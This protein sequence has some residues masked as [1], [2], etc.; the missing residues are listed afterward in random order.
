MEVRKELYVGGRWVEPQTDGHIDVIDSRTE[1]VMGSVPRGGGAE[2]ERAV[3]AAGPRLPAGRRH[4][5]RNGA[6]RC[7]PS[8]TAWKRTASSSPRR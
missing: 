7:A 3:A 8:P 2:V 5:S 1:E 6:P 4:P